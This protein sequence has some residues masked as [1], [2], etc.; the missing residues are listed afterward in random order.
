MKN[1]QI[2]A[3]CFIIETVLDEHHQVKNGRFAA[4][5]FFTLW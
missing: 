5:P 3:S 4:G 1:V 2:L